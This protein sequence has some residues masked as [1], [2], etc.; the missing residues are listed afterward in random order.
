MNTHQQ[1]LSLLKRLLQAKRRKPGMLARLT[2]QDLVM[3]CGLAKDEMSNRHV[4]LKLKPPINVVSDIRG[5]F[6]DLLRI[7]EANGEPPHEN[8]LFLGNII[9][10]GGQSIEA[11]SLLFIYKILYPEKVYLLRGKHEYPEVNATEGFK[12]ECCNRYSQRLW[13]VFNDVFSVMPYAAV[14]GDKIFAVNSG[15]SP[16]FDSLDF[17]EHIERPVVKAD[18]PFLDMASAIPDSSV[19]EWRENPNGVSYSF[20]PSQ[21]HKFLDDNDLDVIVRGNQEVNGGFDFPFEPDRSVVTIYSSPIYGDPI[22]NDGAIMKIDES[23]CCSFNKIKP[24][25]RRFF[26]NFK[27]ENEFQ[28]LMGKT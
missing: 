4:I 7:F 24:L 5:K 22:G 27:E 26:A 25:E 2:Q 28:I 15:I 18:G 12:T 10:G 1:L 23:L 6:Y 14:I 17:F 3:I 16:H 13:N 9:D 11:I 20:G 8:Y 19:D 21:A